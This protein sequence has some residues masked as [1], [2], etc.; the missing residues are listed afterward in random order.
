MV[1]L[2]TSANASEISNVIEI[3]NETL[4]T[5]PASSSNSTT[6]WATDSVRSSYGD[7]SVSMKLDSNGYPVILH[8][9][10]QSGS[11]Y[12]ALSSWNG[13]DWEESLIDTLGSRSYYSSLA[14]DSDDHPHVTFYNDTSMDLM[15]A[16][17]N[18]TDWEKTIVDS[19]GQVG[20]Y[21]GMVLDGDDHPH[22]AY[23]N[24]SDYS[25]K[26]SYKNT[27]G[28]HQMDLIDSQ[29]GFLYSSPDIALDSSGNPHILVQNGSQYLDYIFYDGTGWNYTKSIVQTYSSPFGR[30]ISALELD[31]SDNVHIIY[32][33]TQSKIDHMSGR[34]GTWTTTT[35][36][37]T[38]DMIKYPDLTIDADDHPHIVSR[39]TVNGVFHVNYTYYTGSIWSTE[40]VYNRS[41]TSDGGYNSNIDINGDG[42]VFIAFNGFGTKL[43]RR[44][45]EK[46]TFDF[47]DNGYELIKGNTHRI[48]ITTSGFDPDET[49]KIELYQAN[50]KYRQNL[51]L[52]STL[53]TTLDAGSDHFNWTLPL[54]L[55]VG[56]L[57][58]LRMSWTRWDLVNSDSNDFQIVADKGWFT[59]RVDYDTIRYENDI[60]IDADGNPHVA[61]MDID[62]NY[63]LKYAKWTNND[64][65][66][67]TVDFDGKVGI[68][69]SIA[70][71]EDNVPHIAYYE[72]DNDDIRYAWKN[73]SSWEVLLVDS[74]LTSYTYISLELNSSG[75][76][77]IAYFHDANDDMKLARSSNNSFSL[78]TVDSNG[79]TGIYPSLQIDSNDL[80]HISYRE[81]TG[82]RF[83][84]YAH[85]NGTRWNVTYLTRCYDEGNLQL[86][87]NDIPHLVYTAVNY[88]PGGG[89][90]L[91]HFFWNGTAWDHEVVKD[92][93]YLALAKMA[94]DEND[95]IHIAYR[96]LVSNVDKMLMYCYNNGTQWNSVM[97]F[98]DEDFNNYFS[99]AA[100]NGVPHLITSWRDQY[101]STYIYEMRY[102]KLM[103][104]PTVPS[105]PTISNVKGGVKSVQIDFIPS[106]DD[107]GLAVEKYELYVGNST[108]NLTHV[109]T[110]LVNP[111]AP[112][113]YFTDSYA[114]NREN[115]VYQVRA[116]NPVGRSGSSNNVSFYMN[117]SLLLVDDDGGSSYDEQ[118]EYALI[119]SNLEYHILDTTSSSI[120]IDR[121][122]RYDAVIWT[123][124]DQSVN[125]L[126][127][128]DQ[129]ALSTYLSEGGAL[130]LSGQD[131]LF[132]LNSGL[133]GTVTNDFVNRYLNV[134]GFG[135]VAYS[136]VSGID[137][138][139]ISGP[140]ETVILSY[141]FTNY[142]DT[143]TMGPGG[144][145][146][147]MDGGTN[148]TGV[149]VDNSTF[150]VIF[151]GFPFE[152][153]RNSNSSQGDELMQR[154]VEWL[155][156]DPGTPS[157]PR[158]ISLV[159]GSGFNHLHWDFP[160]YNGTAPLTDHVVYRKMIAD[161]SFSILARVSVPGMSYNDTSVTSGLVY[162]YHVVA[163]NSVGMSLSTRH[164]KSDENPPVLVADSS[165]SAAY[166][167][168]G[169]EFSIAVTDDQVIDE[170]SVEYW[171]GGGQ[172][173]TTPLIGPSPY[174][175]TINIPSGSTATL[176]YRFHARDKGDNTATSSLADILVSD[177]DLPS[178]S[179]LTTQS[180]ATTGETFV[181]LGSARDN[182]DMDSW[183]LLYRFG[184]DLWTNITFTGSKE[185]DIPL[186]SDDNLHYQFKASDLADNWNSTPVVTIIVTDNDR[187]YFGTDTSSVTIT[188]GDPV[189]FEI[190]VY[191][192]IGVI[193][194]YME[195]WYGSGTH[196]NLTLSGSGST[197]TTTFNALTDTTAS[198]HYL[199]WSVDDTGNWAGTSERTITIFDD[200]R[201]TFSFDITP[202]TATTGEEVMFSIE[203]D[204][205]IEVT[206][207][208]LE[209]WFGNYQ[210][211]NI[212]LSGSGT[213][214]KTI[215]IPTE[216]LDTLHYFFSAVDSSDNWGST[217]TSD[218]TISDND[219]PL[220]GTD[221]TP[222]SA[223]TGDGLTFSIMVT[224]NVGISDVRLLYYQG[225]GPQMNISV[226][227][228]QY[229]NHTIVVPSNDSSDY[230]YMFQAVDTSGNWVSSS[231][232]SVTVEDNDDP[233]LLS[234]LTPTVGGTGDAFTFRISAIDNIG[235]DTV[236]VEY[237][238]GSGGHSTLLLSQG[239]S[240]SGSIFIPLSRL[241]PMY[242][243][244]TIK[245]SSDNTVT[246]G[247]SMVEVLDNDR[248]RMEIG[249]MI[250]LSAPTGAMLTL[251]LST[252]DNIGVDTVWAEYWFGTNPV[253]ENVT[254]ESPPPTYR[255]MLQI[256][257]DSLETLH[258]IFKLNDTSDNWFNMDMISIPLHD[259]IL[260]IVVNDTTPADGTTGDPFDFSLEASD[261]IGISM[262]DVE[263][264][265]GEGPAVKVEMTGSGLYTVGTTL[266]SDSLEPLN[267]R[268][269]LTDGSGNVNITENMTVTIIDNDGPVLI[270][271]L[272]SSTGTTGDDLE[273]VVSASDNVGIDHINVSYW[274]VAGGESVITLSP[275]SR[276]TGS[277]SLPSE[278]FTLL[279]YTITIVDSS[280]NSI[281][282]DEISVS[283]LDDD[284][285]E[286]LDSIVP[287]SV[288]TPGAI[289]VSLN[290]TDNRDISEVILISSFGPSDPVWISMTHEDGVY[291]AAIDVP[292]YFTGTAHLSYRVID[293]TGN[294]LADVLPDVLVI[295]GIAPVIA[296][297]GD[298]NVTAGGLIE[299]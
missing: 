134:T 118:F 11:R 86:D 41:I 260:P 197:Y 100:Y 296:E 147:F 299:V 59:T 210:E 246:S 95:D 16:V 50:P 18:G 273:F 130:F 213:Y 123:T 105:P 22:I 109:A 298:I 239:E 272:T 143:L 47:P 227:G 156:S 261:N 170:V 196:T 101:F 257:W 253:H 279:M 164:I 24:R 40:E 178:L 204:D 49:L 230:S 176:H 255:F 270:E 242:Y 166:T 125:T 51:Y 172:R 165:P 177:D 1:P 133:S 37:S 64:W 115:Y 69:A 251:A 9:I 104:Y 290:V 250:P 87:S 205:N 215:D 61:Y 241:Y 73:G 216:G 229:R 212:S 25:L 48:N 65:F 79:Q 206:S 66:I 148:T 117:V 217:S 219:L 175:L 201:P 56:W 142:A 7:H 108:E 286:L 275:G 23:F 191:D 72:M 232:S 203:V 188:T 31:S 88:N 262:I 32:A 20:E 278:G 10:Y 174:T 78:E 287:E 295:D 187:P 110:I 163:N 103:G 276:F 208:Y 97:L 161:S 222:G 82:D 62:G 264:W 120:T 181:F 112:L 256:P 183:K 128:D 293:P 200:D 231:W 254:L 116:V 258:M 268:F 5:S 281:T 94:I 99:I 52:R 107:G 292:D 225:S 57:Y 220:F 294:I 269:I 237:W 36:N 4:G 58:S 26:Y 139:I 185:I 136:S 44:N 149:R 223:T 277:I 224:D 249:F 17:W 180:D 71:D 193:N 76:P 70:V 285:P 127:A 271:D 30:D 173:T 160:E 27:T 35:L 74:T 167:G 283:I 106:S 214:S 119:A 29:Y 234:D 153:F 154:S 96:E 282:T 126:K 21:S 55:E 291:T 162:V 226:P 137:N 43:S 247:T 252:S 151:L 98:D 221:G 182:V 33:N 236:E 199:F 207:V 114:L 129:S 85:Y 6:W 138:D 140:F 248:P 233:L 67:E 3:Q 289:T 184:T 288:T 2:D 80:P 77:M 45:K 90:Q 169:Y 159:H 8:L 150:R 152:A 244:V 265:F 168:N 198:I 15:Y 202:T 39:G 189:S 280:G 141:P 135:E 53:T 211:I 155:L 93:G 157:P 144:N 284:I 186:D 297:I 84:R 13:T 190:D 34:A 192:N 42:V 266:P 28:W 122:G 194:V 14:I 145:G 19:Y 121:L 209:Y 12:I 243:F 102:H 131:I 111:Y 240:Y 274:F 75:K 46:I 267:Y 60:A 259:S 179:D 68:Y 235:I 54:D 146:I 91:I 81:M 245:D 63:S 132:D 124:G 158:N 92:L 83:L 38:I 113:L 171:F 238:F 195:Y 263:Y 218:I 228:G 89:Y